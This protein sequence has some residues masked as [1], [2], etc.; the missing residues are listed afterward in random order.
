MTWIWQNSIDYVSGI[1]FIDKYTEW[2]SPNNVSQ[3]LPTSVETFESVHILSNTVFEN[4]KF[5]VYDK[6]ENQPIKGIWSNLDNLKTINDDVTSFISMNTFNTSEYEDSPLLYANDF[7][8]N[9]PSGATINGIEVKIKKSSS[10]INLLE[11]LESSLPGIYNSFKIYYPKEFWF[12]EN[13]I[14]HYTFDDVV[15]LTKSGNTNEE[16]SNYENYQNNL[17]GQVPQY[18]DL[19]EYSNLAKPFVTEYVS[20]NY[21]DTQNYVNQ[22]NLEYVNYNNYHIAKPK[23]EWRESKN[24]IFN[25]TSIYGDKNNK[26]GSEISVNDINN[27]FGVYFKCKQKVFRNFN[28]FYDFNTPLYNDN[29]YTSYGNLKNFNSINDRLNWYRYIFEINFINPNDDVIILNPSEF[30]KYQLQSFQISN[31]HSI[32]MRINYKQEFDNTVYILSDNDNMFN[33]GNTLKTD[34]AYFKYQTCTNGI[35]YSHITNFDDIYQLN[36]LNNDNISLNNMYNEYNV[37]NKYIP[38]DFINI[39]VATKENIDLNKEYFQIDNVNLKPNHKILLYGQTSSQTNDIYTVNENYMLENS[40]ILSTREKSYRNKCYVKMGS[41]QGKEFHLQPNGANFPITGE[42]K[43]FLTGHSYLLKHEINYNI[44][45]TNSSYTYDNS[46]N[47]IGNPNKIIFT[48]YKHARTLSETT[49]WN[50]LEL[51]L[52]NSLTINYELLDEYIITSDYDR[53]EYEFTGSTYNHTIYNWSGDTYLK[54]NIDF[55]GK[56]NIGDYILFSIKESGETYSGNMI[57]EKSLFNYFTNVKNMNTEYLIISEIPTWILNNINNYRFRVRNLHYC[58]ATTYDYSNYLNYSPFS[59]ILNF[60]DLDNQL[61]ISTKDSDNYKYFDYN[62]ITINNDISSS[63]TSYTFKTDNQ[64]QNYKLKPFLDIL[65]TTPVNIY[66][67]N[68]I[69]N[70]EYT[71][72][73]IYPDYVN[74]HTQ[75]GSYYPIQSSTYKI[76]PTDNSVL[77][78]FEPYTYIDF[79]ILEM[80]GSDIET[81]YIMNDSGRTLIVDVNSDY[82]IIEKPRIDNISGISSGNYDIINVSKLEDISNILYEIYLNYPHSYY[83][84]YSENI[85]NKICS[86]YAKI[87]KNNSMIRNISTGIIYQEDDLYNFDLFNIDMNNVLNHNNDLNLMYKPIELIDIG[88]DKKTKSPIPLNVNNLSLSQENNLWYTGTTTYNN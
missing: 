64:Y 11:L 81:P 16:Y 74:G 62:L 3:Y 34:D 33:Y 54:N 23:G 50:D 80:S 19:F 35:C 25:T 61:R 85:Y 43:I 87:V 14:N 9:I 67:E 24:L 21:S 22:Y 7:N 26:W 45:N 84:K 46:G 39:D 88:I 17:N 73:E 56:T 36:L 63:N 71:I 42:S 1:S 29:N 15:T 31:I 55:S 2:M 51:D 44:F 37:I 8:F 49:N 78:F 60:I 70:S 65:G 83:Y 66:N 82:M 30:F 57:E 5:M 76:T 86:K 27:D 28:Y 10:Y 38:N 79:G 77:D 13:K 68:Y 40:N 12:Y 18:N 75:A 59:E 53:I 72:S 4:S 6:Y 69:L 41:D 52:P 47:T 32:Q 20:T 58:S 48:N